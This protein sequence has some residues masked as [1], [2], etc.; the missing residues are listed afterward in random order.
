M[1]C[2][3]LK[4]SSC[5]LVIPLLC[6][7]W[8][9]L[10]SLHSFLSDVLRGYQGGKSANNPCTLQVTTCCK[11]RRQHR[12]ILYYLSQ[13]SQAVMELVYD[14]LMEVYFGHLP[15]SQ[16]MI[17]YEFRCL[18]CQMTTRIFDKLRRGAFLQVLQLRPSLAMATLARGSMMKRLDLLR[19]AQIID[20]R[21]GLEQLHLF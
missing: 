1:T 16:C 2:L 7:I 8:K 13:P 20:Q 10:L 9:V 11:C 5:L 21:Q 4:L 15:I 14:L 18:C 17:S 19:L 12:C 6:A 3:L